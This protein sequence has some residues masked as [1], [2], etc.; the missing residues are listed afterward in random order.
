V[1]KRHVSQTAH[2]IAAGMTLTPADASA[3]APAAETRAIGKRNNGCQIQ[4]SPSQS[5]E[6]RQT[7]FLEIFIR[8]LCRPFH[9]VPYDTRMS[10][11]RLRACGSVHNTRQEG[12]HAT[13]HY[14]RSCRRHTP[15]RAGPSQLN[16]RQLRPISSRSG[17]TTTHT[18]EPPKVGGPLQSRAKKGIRCRR[19]DRETP[20]WP[21]SDTRFRHG[22]RLNTPG[23]GVAGSGATLVATTRA[24]KRRMLRKTALRKTR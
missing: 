11:E 13:T 3:S 1:R 24:E 14:L 4:I 23:H 16:P 18:E 21:G 22:C 2:V 15:R 12:V 7:G 19:S 20:D 5:P 6:E 10:A 8:L 9:G 17:E